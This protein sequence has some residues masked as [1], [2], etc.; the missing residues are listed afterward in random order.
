M[1]YFIFSLSVE[2]LCNMACVADGIS[3]H[4]WSFKKV[5]WA[6]QFSQLHIAQ[7]KGLPIAQ[8]GTFCLRG[9]CPARSD[10]E[11][12]SRRLGKIS[13]VESEILGFGLSPSR[14]FK[15]AMARESAAGNCLVS[16]AEESFSFRGGTH[17]AQRKSNNAS[18]SLCGG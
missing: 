5:P 2:S 12:F 1:T 14:R 9:S 16:G 18:S 3:G 15:G 10:G 7:C 13:L 6:E 8:S 4:C 11:E 17:F